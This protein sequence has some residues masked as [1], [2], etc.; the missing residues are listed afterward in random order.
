MMKIDLAPRIN[1]KPL[2]SFQVTKKKSKLL[3][4]LQIQCAS[5]HDLIFGTLCKK[6]E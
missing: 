5:I 6:V 4:Y 2:L 1:G 3:R